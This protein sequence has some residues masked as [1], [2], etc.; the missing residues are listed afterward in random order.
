MIRSLLPRLRR[1]LGLPGAPVNPQR[2]AV[3]R[4]LAELSTSDGRDFTGTVLVD[5]TWDNPNYWLRY[6]LFRAALGLAGREV[7]LLGPYRPDECR[8]TF[9][10][11]GVTRTLRLSAFTGN[12]SAARA[13]AR[14]RLS[15]TRDQ[16]DILEWELDGV[17]AYDLYDS[18]LKRQRQAVVDLRHPRLEDDVT[19]YLR[20]MEATRRMLAE[21]NPQ[22]VLVSHTFSGR[23]P[24]GPLVW[25][26]VQRGTP[27]VLL[28]GNYGVLRFCK[29]RSA[30]EVLNAIDCPR[31]SDLD[32][33]SGQQEDAFIRSGRE[34]LE[35]RLRGQMDDIGSRFAF[36]GESSLD[37]ARL[38]GT[39]GW[40]SDR[41][42]VAVYASTW[43]DAPHALGMTNFRN[44]S[45]WLT[46]TLEV[47]RRRREVSWLFRAH[48]CDAL[49]GGVTL[50]DM[51]PAT[52][53]AHVRLCPTEWT[54]S[55]ILNA[56]DAVVTIQGTAGVEYAASGKAVLLADRSWYHDRGFAK[57]CRSRQDYLDQLARPWWHDLD[58]AVTTRRARVFAGWYFCRPAWHEGFHVDDDSRQDQLYPLISGLLERYPHV[59]QRE[60]S[61]I[62]EWYF[63]D[64]PYYHTFKMKRTTEYALPMPVP[65]SVLG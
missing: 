20:D 27:L 32:A 62:R 65:F 13:E 19:E 15:E 14:R 54:S 37:R 17:P 63:S 8:R 52:D 29:M 55:A 34:Y 3:E 31:G 39:L 58:L 38:C 23:V 1:A 25:L 41:P 36:R 44:F 22:L 49:Y 26:S 45:D 10:H 9:T 57:W 35:S 50:K 46:A 43:F 30:A 5:G 53:E 33:V 12:E 60:I 11:L 2:D 47:A 59:V 24:L 64:D 48:P 16:A 51:M 4:R 56:A 21:T 61:E 7:G 18:L 28:F 42:I 6:S 40:P